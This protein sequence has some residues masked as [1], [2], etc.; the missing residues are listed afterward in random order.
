MQ[1]RQNV[2]NTSGHQEVVVSLLN[3][4]CYSNFSCLENFKRSFWN[5]MILQLWHYSSGE[6]MSSPFVSCP[7]LFVQAPPGPGSNPEWLVE[8]TSTFAFSRA[9]IRFFAPYK[10]NQARSCRSRSTLETNIYKAYVACTLN[11]GP[12]RVRQ[13]RN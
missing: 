10:W 3:L 8:Y 1:E 11:A 9:S 6:A 5:I 13:D 4:S 12:S 7:M 2:S